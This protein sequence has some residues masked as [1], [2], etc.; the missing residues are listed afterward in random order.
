MRTSETYEQSYPGNASTVTSYP[1]TFQFIDAAD[2]EL[3]VTDTLGLQTILTQP[4]NYVVTRDSVTELGSFVTTLAHPATST[5][6]IYRNN[7]LTQQLDYVNSDTFPAASHEQS[8]DRFTESLQA[9][10]AKASRALRVSPA[11]SEQ[12]FEASGS[13]PNTIAGLGA[14]GEF[15]F[16]TSAEMLS[17]MSLTAPVINQPTKTWANDGE[18]ALAVPDFLGQ[19]GVQRN[20][21]AVYVST[22]LG[23]GNWMGVSAATVADLS[24]TREKIAD[25]ALTADALG[26]AKMVDAFI[27]LAKMSTDFITAMTAKALLEDGDYLAGWSATDNAFRKFAG[28]TAIPTGS[29]IQTVSATPYVANTNII[30]VIPGDDTVPQIAEGTQILTLSITPRFADSQIRLTFNGSGGV[31]T[32][33]TMIAALFRSPVTNALKVTQHL[34][35][36]NFRGEL[37]IDWIDSPATTSATTYTIRVGAGSANTIRM[38]GT[39][40]ARLF[41]GAAACT[42]VAQEIKV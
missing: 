6:K 24:I 21:S 19:I 16:R 8:M 7:V 20:T 11:D 40:T 31:T 33:G 3:I 30:A 17:F 35:A 13:P 26:R 28:G 4:A 34:L 38:N 39:A 25:G 2:L 41:G 10:N 18:R 9:V 36:A 29:V 22:G 15:L 12:E 32:Q 14:A 27:T 1:I 37:N 23:A 5:L 42:L